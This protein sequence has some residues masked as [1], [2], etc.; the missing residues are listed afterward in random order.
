MTFIGIGKIMIVIVTD[1]DDTRFMTTCLAVMFAVSRHIR[2]TGRTVIL[3]ASTSTKNG[4]S[5]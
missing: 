4:F 1:S 2:V 3:V 5:H